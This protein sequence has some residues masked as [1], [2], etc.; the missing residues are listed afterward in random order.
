MFHQSKGGGC[1]APTTIDV[2]NIFFT[3]ANAV[4]LLSALAVGARHQQYVSSEQRWWMP[5]YHNRYTQ[6][7]FHPRQPGGCLI[8]VGSRGTA[9][10]ICFIRAKV[11]DAVL[12]QSIYTIFFTPALVVDALPLPQ[13]IYTIFFTPALVVDALPLPQSIYIVFFISAKVVDAVPLPQSIY[14]ICFT[15]ANVVD[16]VSLP[17]SI[18]TICF[19]PANVVDAVLLPKS[20]QLPKPRRFGKRQP[21]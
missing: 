16:A 4:D 12:P 9:S 1:R 13:S 19:T 5:C 8:W 15:P 14:T 11:V 3:R 18:Y 10:T 20:L 6:Y 21:G 17:Q 7:F 2:R